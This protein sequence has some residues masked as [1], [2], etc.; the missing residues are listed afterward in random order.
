MNGKKREETSS[1]ERFE[2]ECSGNVFKV[3]GF[4]R[5]QENHVGREKSGHFS[6][7][8][9]TRKLNFFLKKVFLICGN[10]CTPVSKYGMK[11]REK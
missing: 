8:M 4:E 1:K 5:G 7:K 10:F 3:T 11:K 9:K 6:Y 2:T